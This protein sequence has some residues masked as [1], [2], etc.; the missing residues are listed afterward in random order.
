MVSYNSVKFNN[1]AEKLDQILKNNKIN[2]KDSEEIISI[3]AIHSIIDY[4]QSALEPVTKFVS[5]PC[6]KCGEIHLI[7]MEST[8]K[9]NIIFRIGNILLK[10]K[11]TIP[12][13][14]CENCGSTHAVLPDFCVPFKQYSND[15]ILSIVKE[16]SVTSIEEVAIKLDIEP[17]Q[18][19]RFVNA[20]NSD[21]NNISLLYQIYKDDFNEN[22]D[23]D[24][25]LYNLVNA[26]PTNITGLYFKQFK[27]IFLYS[28]TKRKIYITYQKL[29]T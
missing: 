11:I 23:S 24:S 14:I 4:M 22:I 3:V 27:S 7:P 29:L 15:T 19:R 16:T 9:R 1:I 21:K 12:R 17:N 25:K 18:V 26:I 6:P 20:V 2:I 10:L 13:L 28:K 5:A 8:Y